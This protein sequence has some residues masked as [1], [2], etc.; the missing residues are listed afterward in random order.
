MKR[1]MTFLVALC[2]TFSL[3]AC[4]VSQSDY[5]AL[6]EE[7]AS[8]K[9][10]VE[11][12]QSEVES[13]SDQN[14]SDKTNSAN[15]DFEEFFAE[16]NKE[17]EKLASE[18]KEITSGEFYDSVCEVYPDISIIELESDVSIS[19]FIKHENEFDDSTMFFNAVDDIIKTSKIENYY[20]GVIFMMFVDDSF[21]AMFN[22]LDYISPSSFVSSEPV[23]MRDEYKESIENLYLDKFSSSDI[24]TNFD[25]SLDELS[26]KYK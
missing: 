25:R 3:S 9:D 20:S 11:S 12:L 23:I 26:D 17:A 19:I 24:S 10:Q 8:L 16:A 22:L 2:L 6:K 1:I 15:M 4:G 13:P 14:D 18:S 5:D 21:I 7:N